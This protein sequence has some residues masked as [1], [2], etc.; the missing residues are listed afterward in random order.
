[1]PKWSICSQDPLR[2]AHQEGEERY[3]AN[4]HPKEHHLLGGHITAKFFNQR[5]GQAEAEPCRQSK[6]YAMQDS[7]SG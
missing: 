2:S 5:E 1:M 4:R 6:K 7:R 3:Q